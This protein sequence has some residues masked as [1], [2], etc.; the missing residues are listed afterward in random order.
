MGARALGA[1]GVDDDA[2]RTVMNVGAGAKKMGATAIGAVVGKVGAA[3]EA[4]G[5]K[6]P[7]K[8][9]RKATITAVVDFSRKKSEEDV[10]VVVRNIKTDVKLF[11][12][13][14]LS[15]RANQYIMT[16]CSRKATEAVNQIADEEKPSLTGIMRDAAVDVGKA[17]IGSAKGTLKNLTQKFDNRQKNNQ[18][19]ADDVA[20]QSDERARAGTSGDTSSELKAASLGPDART[21]AAAETEGADAA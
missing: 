16:A 12:Y 4:A 15:E 8:D 9:S 19:D 7:A 5:T 2:R 3:A 10:E 11:E 18:V 13:L 21:K 1:L 20:D 17:K 14:M 6:A